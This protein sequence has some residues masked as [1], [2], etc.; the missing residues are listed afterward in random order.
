M[1]LVA[2]TRPRGRRKVGHWGRPGGWTVA[3]ALSVLKAFRANQGL[4][5]AGGVAYYTLLSLVPLLILMLIVLSHLL[6]E[7]RLLATLSEYLQFIVPGQSDVVAGELRAFL[8][9]RDQVGGALLVV[10]LFFSA[11]A[12]TVLENAMSVIFFHRV[13]VRRRRFIVS[14][15]MPYC[16]IFFLGLGLLVVTV[17]AG[18]LA[19]LATREVMLFGVPRSLDELSGYLLYLLGV[20]GEILILTAI[21]L[22]MPVGR[23]SL[24]HALIGGASAGVLWEITRHVLVWY[25]GTISQVRIVYGSFATAIAVLLSVEIAA[26]VLLLGAQVIAEFE[27]SARGVPASAPQPMK[28]AEGRRRYP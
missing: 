22:V 1:D 2:T 9:H 28:L 11:L 10:M 5:L 6:D 8:R 19:A 17:V 23:L 18:K 16:F 7:A 15:L 14:A 24:R 4:L 3:F 27:R 12:F 21:Y 26:I 13:A 20:A 25:Y